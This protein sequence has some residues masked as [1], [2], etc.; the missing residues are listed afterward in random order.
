MRCRH[1]TPAATAEQ[2]LELRSTFNMAE[3]TLITPDLNETNLGD[4]IDD[5][6]AEQDDDSTDYEELPP[7][8]R[9]VCRMYTQ[10][11]SQIGMVPQSSR[12]TWPT[13]ILQLS[14]I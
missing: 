4:N 2:I 10:E 6:V 14:A 8:K 3:H 11:T 9:Q 1:S 7:A 13:R 5:S 12:I